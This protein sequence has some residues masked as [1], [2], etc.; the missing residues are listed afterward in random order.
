VGLRKKGLGFFKKSLLIKR[1]F[2]IQDQKKKTITIQINN[3]I[4][5]FH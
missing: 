1:E 4:I 5:N 2:Y 3:E